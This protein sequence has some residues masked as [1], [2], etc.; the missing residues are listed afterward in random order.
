MYYLGIDGGGTR[1]SVIVTDE[2]GVPLARETGDSINYN[3]VGLDAARRSMAKIMQRLA[4]Y[5]F[6]H[7][8]CAFIGMS[9]VS[10]RAGADETERFAG[11]IISADKIIMDS[12]VFAAI[13]SLKTEQPCAVTIAGTGSMAAGRLSDGTVIHKGGW[14]HLLGDEGSA[15][16]IASEGLHAAVRGC[17]KSGES[18]LLSEKL[19]GFTM[20]KSMDDIIGEFYNP[21]MERNKLA[22]FSIKVFEAAAEN[23]AVAAEILDRQS[24]LL[25]QTTLALLREMGTCSVLGVWGGV[26]E[27]HPEYLEAFRSHIAAEYPLLK[28]ELLCVPPEHGAAFAAIRES[29]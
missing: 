24:R 4:A 27:N 26:F 25:A 29:E 12:D 17:D 21:V 3:S 14:G 19:F 20:A 13:S 11:G 16:A 18:T 5:E 8:R 23:D 7:F 10:G 2:N 6:E 1:T 9:A 22:R 28:A 15:F